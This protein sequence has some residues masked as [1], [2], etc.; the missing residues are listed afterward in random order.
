MEE[1]EVLIPC[2]NTAASWLPALSKNNSTL[3]M[4]FYLNI[5]CQSRI[6]VQ[7]RTCAAGWGFTT[8]LTYTPISNTGNALVRSL[9][10]VPPL[11][12]VSWYSPTTQRPLRWAGTN[13]QHGGSVCP[14]FV[15]CI[16]GVMVCSLP[17]WLSKL[18]LHH[19]M[20]LWVIFIIAVIFLKFFNVLNCE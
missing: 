9:C 17:S 20:W 1:A 4:L 11:S 15:V 10:S 16:H 7:K 12:K 3:C 18:L 5:F 19:R 6:H 14:V 2:S 8:A 13:Q